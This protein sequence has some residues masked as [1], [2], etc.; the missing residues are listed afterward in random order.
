MKNSW[1]S[2]LE[3]DAKKLMRGYFSSSTL[4]R[5]RMKKL[6]E[7]KIRVRGSNV[8]ALDEFDKPSWAYKQADRNGYERALLEVIE[9]IS[10]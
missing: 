4:L 2:G 1:C 3:P 5:E 10:K 6:L 9:L 8:I 7:D